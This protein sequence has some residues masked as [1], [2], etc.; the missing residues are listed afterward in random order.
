MKLSLSMA[1]AVSGF[2]ALAF[3]SAVQAQTPAYTL[4]N[5]TG[6][7]L[8]N[9]PFT[10]GSQFVANS[11]VT[12][13]AL[14]VFDDSQNGLVDSYATGLFDSNGNLL[15]SATVLSGTADPLVNQFRYASINPVTLVAGDT[16]EI[17]ALY[18]DGNDG[19]VGPGFDNATNF[20]V[21][22]AI[23][24]LN[25]AYTSGN[26]LSAPTISV[27]GQ[28]YF[29]PNMLLGSST[30]NVPEPG[31]YALIGSLGLTAVGFLRRKRSR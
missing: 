11:A 23:S 25:S 22:P 7:T 17:G 6:P 31:A 26:T 1:V 12:V 9:P 8:V 15:A 20:A 2:A 16:Y 27:N 28:G 19:I 4:D 5:L 10:L 14:G 18:L 29:G 24:F 3:G 13:T 21:N 30:S